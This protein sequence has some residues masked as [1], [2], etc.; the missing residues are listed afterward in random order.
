[1]SA[2]SMLVGKTQDEMHL[3]KSMRRLFAKL[4]IRQFKK[5][6]LDGIITR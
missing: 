5:F 2:I 4:Y 3:L 1:M 6:D